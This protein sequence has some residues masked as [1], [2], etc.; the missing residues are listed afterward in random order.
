MSIDKKVLKARQHM[1][2]VKKQE[3]FN[4][5]WSPDEFYQSLMEV[6]IPKLLVDVH[7]PQYE[8]LYK[9]IQGYFKIDKEMYEA[10]KKK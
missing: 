2:R 5:V 6:G 10:K 4:R 1:K 3:D 7:A 8:K 9:T